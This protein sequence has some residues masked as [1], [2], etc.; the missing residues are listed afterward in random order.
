MTKVKPWE[1]VS[2][3]F[4]DDVWKGMKWDWEIDGCW[5]DMT[6]KAVKDWSSQGRRN[7]KMP[8]NNTS[9]VTGV[10]W[11]EPTKKWAARISGNDGAKV[12]GYFPCFAV[13]VRARRQA[14]RENG[15]SAR[16][17]T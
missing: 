10:S 5:E 3:R 7:S 15:F 2:V 14:E 16:H 4:E 12:L 8:S 9:G 6:E 11:F 1:P 13:A 17:G